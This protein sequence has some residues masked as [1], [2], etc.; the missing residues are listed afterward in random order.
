MMPTLKFLKEEHAALLEALLKAY[1]R[2]DFASCRRMRKNLDHLESLIEK[3][4]RL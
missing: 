3:A 4:K 2:K 1:E